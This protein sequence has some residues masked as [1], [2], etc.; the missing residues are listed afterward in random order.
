MIIFGIDPG[1]RISGFGIIECKSGTFKHINHGSIHLETELGF[2]DRMLE[3]SGSLQGLLQKY[4][5]EVVVIEKIFLG[6]NADSAFKL[7]HAR[8]V[9]ILEAARS[10]ARVVEYA[11]R[12]VK[13][14]LTG[15][16]GADKD[17]VQLFVQR[18]LALKEI[19][20]I[21]ASDAL[22][23]ALYHGFLVERPHL[24]GVEI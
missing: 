14:G 8:G 9:A 5:P 12:V 10:G 6:K 23:L 13:K 7:G 11:T 17:S 4:Q 16:G 24:K 20:Q 3:L 2:A 21:D 18:I 22:A 1:S 19:R 15:H